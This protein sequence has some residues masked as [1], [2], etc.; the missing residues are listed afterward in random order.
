MHGTGGGGGG[1]GGT[2]RFRACFGCNSLLGGDGL[3][4]LARKDAPAEEEDQAAS[5]VDSSGSSPTPRA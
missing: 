5:G 1:S 2:K 4:R 3:G